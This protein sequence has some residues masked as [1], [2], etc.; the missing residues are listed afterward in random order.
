MSNQN[1]AFTHLSSP[2]SLLGLLFILLLP[3]VSNAEGV[4]QIVAVVED[5]SGK[6]ASEKNSRYPT[7]AVTEWDLAPL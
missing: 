6:R 1:T 7:R 5:D 3:A 2:G 4:D